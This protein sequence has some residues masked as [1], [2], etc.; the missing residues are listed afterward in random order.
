MLQCKSLC[1]SLLCNGVKKRADRLGVLSPGR[2]FFA[3]EHQRDPFPGGVDIPGER[4]ESGCLP[5]LAR[6][7]D[8]EVLVQVDQIERTRYAG[9]RRQHVMPLRITRPGGI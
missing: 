9:L 7:M 2:R 6:G 3:G 8:D 4:S 1:E 5:A